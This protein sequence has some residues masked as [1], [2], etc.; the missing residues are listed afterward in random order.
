MATLGAMTDDVLDMVYS[1][2]S[3]DLIVVGGT[4]KVKDTDESS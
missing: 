3:E 1:N 2:P 4:E